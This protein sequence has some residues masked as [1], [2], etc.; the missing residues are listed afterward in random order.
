MG[1]SDDALIRG[2][3]LN[4]NPFV[5]WTR[6]LRRDL[7]LTHVAASAA[8]AL[9]GGRIEIQRRR[10]ESELAVRPSLASL[11][12]VD[13][14]GTRRV[15]VEDFGTDMRTLHDEVVATGARFVALAMP[16]R[17]SEETMR[18]VLLEYTRKLA[19]LAENGVFELVDGRAALGRA[20]KADVWPRDLLI[21]DFHPSSLGHAAL[22]QALA[23]EIARPAKR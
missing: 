16:R 17:I 21:D 2:Q 7:R 14:P 9:R 10:R 6:R 8:D 23:D 3:A 18:P 1:L 19:S 12:A 11:G 13:W 20:I 5:Q 15:S 22:A 4:V